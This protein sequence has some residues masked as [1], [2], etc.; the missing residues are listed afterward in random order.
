MRA[1]TTYHNA[2]A[3]STE[4]T[5][6]L[7]TRTCVLSKSRSVVSGSTLRS[8]ADARFLSTCEGQPGHN[9]LMSATHMG[10]LAAAYQ[11]HGFIKH[12]HTCVLP[13][14]NNSDWFNPQVLGR[15][16][17]PDCSRTCACVCVCVCSCDTSTPPLFRLHACAKHEP[18]NA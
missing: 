11:H 8:S 7:R 6:M 4:H 17:V 2:S 13:I 18:R 15:R 3:L 12:T 1:G 16:M 9:F 14:K 10:A 5:C